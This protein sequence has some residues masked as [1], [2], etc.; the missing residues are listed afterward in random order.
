[1]FRITSKLKLCG[2]KI[3][4]YDMLEKTF[5]T[6]HASNMVLQ[7]QYREKGFTKYSELI[8]LLLVAERNNDLL[9]RNHE[10]RPTGSTPLPEADKVHSHYANHE[11]GHGRGRNRGHSRG[12]RQGRNSHE[13]RQ[14]PRRDNR[15]KQKRDYENPKANSSE[16]IC[17]RCGGKGHWSKACRIPRHLVDLYQASRK[18]K[19]PETNFFSDDNFD[20]T[21]LDVADFFEQPE[22]KIDHLIGDGSVM[23][24]DGAV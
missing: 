7:Q 8:S 13:I 15:R 21:H 5:T 14:P 12:R 6:V 4:D 17:Y 20:I 16:T 22:G 11:K 24:E 19:G 23:K 3:S 10:N 1:M 9:M 18:S 2:D